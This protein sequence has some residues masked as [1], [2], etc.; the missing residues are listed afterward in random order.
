VAASDPTVVSIDPASQT[1]SAGDSVVVTV[2]CA[3]ERP[4]KGFEL[5]LSYD[6]SLLQATSVAEGDFFG[7]H[8][9]FFNPGTINNQAGTI[10]NIYDLI[11]GPGNVTTDGTLVTISFTARSASGTSALTLYEVQLT[12]ETEYIDVSLHSGSVTVVGG[13]APPSNPP[14]SEPP[15]SPEVNAP[16]S[17]PVK[18]LGPALVESG[19]MY[20]YNGSAFDSDGD[21]V[22]LRC[23]WGDGSLSSWSTFVDSNVS[24]SFSHAWQNVS[25]YTVRMIAQ[26][27]HAANSSWSEPL[28]VVVSQAESSNESPVATFVL[29]ANISANQ[30]VLFDASGCVDPDGVIVSYLWDFGDGTQG[31]GQMPTHYYASPGQYTVTLT[32]T[33]NSGLTSSA[34]QLV[35]VSGQASGS[36]P[37]GMSGIPYLSI[38]VL[39]VVLGAA[40]GLVYYFRDPLWMM[41]F[42]RT[43][44]QTKNGVASIDSEAQYIERILDSLFA[45]MKK[46]AVPL[47]KE[48]LLDAY[49]DVI[50]ESVETQKDVRLPD[51][52]ITKVERIVDERYHAE[53]CEQIDKM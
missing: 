46:Q 33:D 19:V 47:S 6:H 50:I 10:I 29:P 40:L 5:K 3:P 25:T 4:V 52:S 36:S 42:G 53:I 7:G 45:E 37:Q 38:L 43:H 27:E 18:P 16:P 44:A 9:T 20:V 12:N 2:V 35:V 17:A 51:L 48:N 32:V 14:P 21:S 11:V 26:D 49:S 15:S 24:V 31:T 23:D 34:S 39:L 1:V 30:T 13:S 8:T 41:L 22:R 28:T